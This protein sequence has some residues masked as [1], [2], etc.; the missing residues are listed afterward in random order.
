MLQILEQGQ[1]IV[2]VVLDIGAERTHMRV[3][4]GVTTMSVI[5]ALTSLLFGIVRFRSFA[6]EFKHMNDI[7]TFQLFR[8][9]TYI[10]SWDM[11]KPL[12]L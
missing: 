4:T 10:W 1:D 12:P 6:V 2:R 8:S 5:S 3:E 11:S 7:L 9:L